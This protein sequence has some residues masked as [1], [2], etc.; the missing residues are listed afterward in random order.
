MIEIRASKEACLC[1][2]TF[3]FYWQHK[4]ERL[5]MDGAVAGV[6]YRRMVQALSSGEDVR[7]SGDVGSRLGSSMG[8]DLVSFGGRGGA[9]EGTGNIVVDGDVAGRMGIS[10][11]RGAIYVSGAVMPPLGNVV[12]AAS[13]MTGYRKF[14]SITEVLEKGLAVLQP[15][16]S[17]E[18]GLVLRDGILRDTIAARSPAGKRVLVEGDVG[19]STGILMSSGEVDVEG[20]AGRNTG[21]LLRGGRVVVRGRSGDFTGVQMRDGEIFVE[22]D[23]GGFICARMRGG[24]VYARSGKCIPPARL[25]PLSPSEQ[26]ALVGILHISALYAMMYHKFSL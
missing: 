14:I 20:D 6:S 4:G 24:A 8:V 25:Q 10:M 3:D 17:D 12:E 15:N 18:S 26:S 22:G 11:L 2:F 16:V 9:I 5:D 7:I 23:A 1:D 21:A 19:M 13:D